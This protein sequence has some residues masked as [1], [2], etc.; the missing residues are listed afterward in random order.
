MPA[1][2]REIPS[3]RIPSCEAAAA[4]AA[5]LHPAVKL[6]IEPEDVKRVPALHSGHRRLCGRHR[7]GFVRCSWPRVSRLFG[8]LCPVATPASSLLSHLPFSFAAA[9]RA[10]PRLPLLEIP[11]LYWVGLLV[12]A[13]GSL[14]VLSSFC[15]LGFTGTFLGSPPSPESE[16]SCV[17]LYKHHHPP[18]PPLLVLPADLCAWGSAAHKIGPTPMDVINT[19]DL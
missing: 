6:E 16:W 11:E 15:A 13:C 9:M 18:P 1:P 4:A 7:G 17:S 12:L 2:H 19:P 5:P 3:P 14:L 10:Q 8:F